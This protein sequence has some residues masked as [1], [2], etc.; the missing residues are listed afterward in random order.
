MTPRRWWCAGDD[1]VTTTP[2]GLSWPDEVYSLS[3]I[4]LPFPPDD[5]LYGEGGGRENPGLRLGRLD[6]RGENRTLAIPNTAMTRQH[7]NPF[8][9]YLSDRTLA[10]VKETA[11]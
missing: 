5:P 11:N 3:H 2:L 6:L 10:F 1:A 7:W 8:F 4:A 9:S